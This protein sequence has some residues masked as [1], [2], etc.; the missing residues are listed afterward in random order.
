V[1]EIG[2]VAWQQCGGAARRRLADETER[3]RRHQ[4]R[5]GE[6]LAVQEWWCER[7]SAVLL[8]CLAAAGWLQGVGVV[9]AAAMAG[10]VVRVIANCLSAM[11][12]V[13]VGGSGC[14]GWSRPACAVVQGGCEL[15]KR[16]G[17]EY[18]KNQ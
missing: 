11:V 10:A 5:R 7:W 3:G 16:G 18:V 12:G 1:V 8:E 9:V 2:V 17:C 6:R 13:R 4:R 14:G 15:L